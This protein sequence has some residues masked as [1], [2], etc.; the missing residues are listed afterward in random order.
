MASRISRT[1]LLQVGLMATCFPSL[2]TGQIFARAAINSPAAIDVT[3]ET[4]A[5]CGL[6]SCP[7]QALTHGYFHEHWRRWPEES[8]SKLPDDA[9]SPFIR[10]SRDVPAVRPPGPREEDSLATPRRGSEDSA[11][12]SGGANRSAAPPVRPATPSIP[13]DEN[14]ADRRTELPSVAPPDDQSPRLDQPAPPSTDSGFFPS[15]EDD[16]AD[17]LPE[18]PGIFPDS[19]LD[20]TL[21]P[22]DFD[23]ESLPERFDAQPPEDSADD[24]FSLDDFSQVNPRR[25]HRYRMSSSGQLRRSRT[26]TTHPRAN[27]HAAPPNR[28]PVQ[29]A[30]YR[31]AAGGRSNPLRTNPDEQ[32]VSTDTAPPQSLPSDWEPEPV[33]LEPVERPAAPLEWTEPQR[34]TQRTRGRSNPLR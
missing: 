7:P 20:S 19:N 13:Q 32:L 10:P 27:P 18:L 2:A 28:P 17:E 26:T 24:V 33:E 22:A 11:E 5:S 8:Q 15:T 12:A 1:L 9:L 16:E 30:G 31:R 25:M 23:E 14:A 6:S 3:S 34:A 4:N 29:L 21:P